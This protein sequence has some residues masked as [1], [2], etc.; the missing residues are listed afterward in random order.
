MEEVPTRITVI[1]LG[2]LP[3]YKHFAK[4]TYEFNVEMSSF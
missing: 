3:T 1:H 2:I 4:V